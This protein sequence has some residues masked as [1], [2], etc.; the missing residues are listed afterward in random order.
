VEQTTGH[1]IEQARVEAGLS[2]AELARRA[3]TSR[4]TLAAYEHGTKSPTL[5]T[6]AR[7]LAAAGFRFDV[8]PVPCFVDRADE[9]G[10]PFS[11]PDRLPRLPVRQALARVRLPVHL[12]WSDPDR[13]YDL[14]DR[15]QRH[16]VYEIVLREGL[17]AD[18]LTYVDGA[19]LVD[20]WPD[21]VLP[22][23]IRRA[24]EQIVLT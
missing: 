17:P 24:W 6:A 3:R 5:D 4:P 21:L 18:L 9:R 20:A 1:L 15:R 10:R 2:G 14:S 12:N 23:A 19:L 11:V 13:V 22:T 8:V 16:R 7:L